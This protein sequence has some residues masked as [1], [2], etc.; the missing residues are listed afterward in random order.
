V[1]TGIVRDVGER[2]R[3]AREREELLNRE[4]TARAEAESARE[5]AESANRAKSQFLATMSHEIRTPMNAIIGYVD[6]LKLGIGG[7][8]SAVQ[9]EHVDRIQSSSAHLLSLIEDILDLARVEAG[10]LRVE[11][12]RALISSAVAEAMKLVAPFVVQGRIEI[13]EPCGEDPDACYFG[14][15]TRVRQIVVNLLSNAVKFTEPGGRVRVSC[16]TAAEIGNETEADKPPRW[17]WVRVEDTGIG[18]AA[19]VLDTIFQPF[20]QLDGGARRKRGGTG[21]GLT[22]SRKLAWLMGGDLTAHSEPGVGSAFTLWL[23]RQRPSDVVSL[24]EDLVGRDDTLGLAQV[25][26]VVLDR[27]P[28][29]MQAFVERVRT[30][31]MI[32][33]ARDLA[34][35]DLQDHIATFLTDVAQALS[36]VERS[37]TDRLGLMQDGTAIQNLISDLH[38]SQRRRLGWNESALHREFEILRSIMRDVLFTELSDAPGIDLDE[39]LRIVDRLLATAERVSLLGWRLADGDKP[40]AP[41]PADP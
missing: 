12:D 10:R 2:V 21:L 5:D 29:I 26:R 8:L 31:P 18:I 19:E 20:V 39:D 27:L 32:P 36:V 3:A 13:S 6:L 4:R 25:G 28:E 38:G 14:D 16:G 17:T 41:P 30:E 34:H 37:Q 9:R 7:D 24:A 23:P 22:I 40:H 33:A 15:A 11:E 35:A 1:F